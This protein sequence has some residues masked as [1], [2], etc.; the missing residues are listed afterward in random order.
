MQMS[1]ILE[2]EKKTSELDWR[3]FDGSRDTSIGTGEK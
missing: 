1:K 3:N 2:R